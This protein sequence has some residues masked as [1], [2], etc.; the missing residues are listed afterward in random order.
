[1]DAGSKPTGSQHFL[2]SHLND[3]W[4]YGA[5]STSLTNIETDSKSDPILLSPLIDPDSKSEITENET[6]IPIPRLDDP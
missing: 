2:H 4:P 5:P 3:L 6:W 1:M